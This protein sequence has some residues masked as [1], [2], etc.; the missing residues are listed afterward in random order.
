MLSAQD[1]DEPTSIETIRGELLEIEKLDLFEESDDHY[2]AIIEL[3]VA[4]P[5]DTESADAAPDDEPTGDDP[6]AADPPDEIE[7]PEVLEVL[8][9]EQ[10]EFIIFG[11]GGVLDV[12][13]TYEARIGEV[14]GGD[15]F[16]ERI[17]Y[18]GE[19]LQCSAQSTIVGVDDL[20]N[21]FAIDVSGFDLPSIPVTP[22]QVAIAFGGL[23]LLTF[24]FREPRSTH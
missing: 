4:E 15:N 3:E 17:A 8:E 6:D 23:A 1:C 10:R 2:R 18:L 9:P 5:A 16:A 12:G 13:E 24:L 14:N 22:R 21:T 7:V 11:K 20:G 19:E